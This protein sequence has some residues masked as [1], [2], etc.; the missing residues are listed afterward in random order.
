[1]KQAANQARA[2]KAKISKEDDGALWHL[3]PTVIIAQRVPSWA[4][5]F[6]T[7]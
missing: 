1:V 4:A 3:A 5:F 6:V 7:L 2:V